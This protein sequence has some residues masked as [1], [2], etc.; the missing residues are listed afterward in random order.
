MTTYLDI[1]DEAQIETF[2]RRWCAFEAQRSNTRE[3]AGTFE[4]LFDPGKVIDTTT[5][6]LWI[7]EMKRVGLGEIA[8]DLEAY[9]GDPADEYP[10]SFVS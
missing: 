1:F 9:R 4:V 7:E 5:T 8:Q 3:A 10:E 6:K 2:K